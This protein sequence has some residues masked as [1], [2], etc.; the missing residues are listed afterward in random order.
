MIQGQERFDEKHPWRSEG[1]RFSWAVGYR[2]LVSVLGTPAPGDSY[3]LA[4]PTAERT[5][6]EI[7]KLPN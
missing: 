3:C 5:A 4:I 6:N 1:M 2:T 7:E